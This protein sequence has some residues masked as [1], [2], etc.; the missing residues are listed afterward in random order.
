MF[1]IPNKVVI[2]SLDSPLLVFEN[3][4][5]SNVVEETGTSAVGDELFI[6]QFVPTVIYELWIQYIIL[7]KDTD[8]Y[9][10]ILTKEGKI[11][12]SKYNYDI[13]EV[14]YGTPVRFYSDGKLTGLYYFSSVSRVSKLEFKFECVSAIGMMGKQRHQGGVYFGKRFDAVLE[15]IIGDDYEY[16]VDS[17]VAEIL[18]YGWL[19]YS[20]RRSNLHKLLMAYGVTITK[21]DTKVMLFTFVNAL[22]YADIPE[23]RI[24]ADGSVEYGEPA[25]RI[26]IIEH[27]YHYLSSVDYEVLFDTQGED[28]NST[29]VIFDH[30][31]YA[32]SLTVEGDNTLVITSKGT[33][34]AVVHGVGILKGKPYIHNTK[35]IS[36]DNADATTEKLVTVDT[37]TL[38]TMANSDNCLTRLSEY[39]FNATVVSE[40]IVQQGE[41]VGKRY[42][43]HN[44]FKEPVSGFLTHM[45]TTVSSF[46][47]SQ[48]EFIANYMPSASGTS[49]SAMTILNPTD[50]EQ[51]W[52]I[53]NSVFNKEN[54]R[55]RCV[56]IGKG[57]DGTAGTD[58]ETGNASVDDDAVGLGGNGGKGGKGGRGGKVLSLTIDCSNLAFIRYKRSGE[59]TILLAADNT[60][61]SE[62]GNTSKT[63]WIEMYTG[64][65]YA[66]AGMD[67][68]DGAMG[69]KGG[70][71]PPIGSSPQK[72]TNGDSVEYNGTT[73]KGGKGGKTQDFNGGEVGVSSNLTIKY[74]GI[75]GGGAA[76]GANGHDGGTG[77]W[78]RD[79]DGNFIENDGYKELDMGGEGAD[80][81][82][83]F[84]TI[85][86]YGNGGNGGHGGG[87][88]GGSNVVYWWNH[89]YSTLMT[90]TSYPGSIGGKGS[91]GTQGN[92][93]C[94]VIYY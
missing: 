51:Q 83:A 63:G 19:P 54:P 90:A 39:Y 29:I 82:A 78:A 25:S 84:F 93:G 4:E 6:D 28:V 33:N 80:A 89:E 21:S 79:E 68:I 2:G 24:F 11:L 72:A 1:A 65:V 16:E 92:D 69:G 75:G 31:I 94:L 48:C 40:S 91:A 26:E 18:V 15:E 10:G 71:N 58:G 59:N 20:T 42:T 5:I 45:L 22:D 57:L 52:T 38:I 41:V 77:G 74:G 23:E 61:S 46:K 7:P 44:P 35:L 43:I 66:Q 9:K 34:F 3:G 64:A 81:A 32:D 50:T 49:F 13:R 36:K 27:S 62:D 55:I 56:L 37:N 47:Q 76:Y 17:D 30:P 88:G 67:G 73:Y 60:Y 14:P 85:D 70:R 86:G 8:K 12:C 87:G 53:P